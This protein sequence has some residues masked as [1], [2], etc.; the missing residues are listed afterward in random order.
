[1]HEEHM[2]CFLR[3]FYVGCGEGRTAVSGIIRAQADRSL[4]AVLSVQC[5]RT[6]ATSYAVKPKLEQRTHTEKATQVQGLCTHY[7]RKHG[8]KRPFV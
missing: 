1:M 7:F 6:P 5:S 4:I 3:D 2:C 8:V